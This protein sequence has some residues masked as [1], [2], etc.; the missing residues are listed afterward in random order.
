LLAQGPLGHVV[1]KGILDRMLK[2]RA[3]SDERQQSLEH[4]LDS[5]NGA[6]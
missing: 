6:A 1:T 3:N 4:L 5:L 2:V